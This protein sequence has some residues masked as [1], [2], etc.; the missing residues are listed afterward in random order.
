[1]EI[2]GHQAGGRTAADLPAYREEPDRLSE[3][4]TAPRQPQTGHIFLTVIIPAYNEESRLPQSLQKTLDW[5]QLQPFQA[6]VLVV[7]DGS[8]DATRAVVENVIARLSE[9]PQ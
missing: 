5:L 8:E 9:T 3:T 4:G 6:E 7:D 2:E 1:M